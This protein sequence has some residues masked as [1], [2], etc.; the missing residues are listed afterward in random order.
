MTEGTK[1]AKEIKSIIQTE[2]QRDQSV[3]IKCTVKKRRS[4]GPS[5]VLIPAITEYQRLYPAYFDHYDIDQIWERIEYNNGEDIKNWERL[6]NQKTVLKMLLQWQR[7]HFTQANE[8]PFADEH[9]RQLLQDKTVQQ[10][11]LSGTYEQDKD[12]PLEAKQLLQEMQRPANIREG[13]PDDTI[14]DDFR[15]YIKNVQERT[16]LSPLRRHCSHYKIFY[17]M[18]KCFLRVIHGVIQLAISNTLL[19]ER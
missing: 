1:A 7:K 19:L 4:G 15:K 17:D 6:T 13:I 5:S 14:F 18:D 12:F 11:I 10:Q 8:T 3:R 9:W 16:S 2:K